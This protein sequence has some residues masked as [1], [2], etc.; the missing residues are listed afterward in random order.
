M[1]ALGMLG[2]IRFS[3]PQMSTILCSI[4]KYVGLYSFSA[5]LGSL[6]SYIYYII[7]GEFL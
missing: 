7:M 1:H 5:M 3:I 2:R 4:L 6:T